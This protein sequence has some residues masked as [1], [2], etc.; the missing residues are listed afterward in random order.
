MK[1][2]KRRLEWLGHVARMGEDRMPKQMLFGYPKPVP[3][4]VPG[5]DGGMWSA[6]T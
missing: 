3:K 5:K 1:T 4:V 6:V 2:T